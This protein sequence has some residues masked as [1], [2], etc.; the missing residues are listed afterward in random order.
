MAGL[1]AMTIDVGYM[2]LVRQEL[3]TSADSGA[4]AAAWTPFDESGDIRPDIA[5]SEA[6]A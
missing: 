5:Q 1:A 4:L 3:Q 2:Y 6:T